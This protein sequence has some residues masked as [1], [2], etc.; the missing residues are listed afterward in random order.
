MLLLCSII[1]GCPHRYVSVSSP[2]SPHSSTYFL[3]KSFT[4]PPSP[5]H[6]TS[7]DARLIVGT[8]VSQ[9]AVDAMFASSSWYPNSHDRLAPFSR[10]NL[11]PD[12]NP[13]SR[14]S[15]TRDRMGKLV[16]WAHLLAPLH[17]SDLGH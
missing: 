3:N 5:F 11:F 8:Y 6:V 13:S 17:A 9:C 1:S 12:G 4:R 10:K 15:F 2:V 14:S 16:V 7:S